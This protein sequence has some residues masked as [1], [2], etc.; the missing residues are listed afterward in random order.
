MVKAFGVWEIEN[1]FTS[2]DKPKENKPRSRNEDIKAV[3]KDKK[4]QIKDPTNT[5]NNFKSNIS[6]E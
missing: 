5:I 6:N 3:E 2:K 1:P 4:K